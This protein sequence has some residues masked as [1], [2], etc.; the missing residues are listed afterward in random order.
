MNLATARD[1]AMRYS[2]YRCREC[3]TEGVIRGVRTKGS[4]CARHA[5]KNY[6]TPQRRLEARRRQL[7]W[8]I[9]ECLFPCARWPCYLIE[10]RYE[11]IHQTELPGGIPIYE[12]VGDDARTLRERILDLTMRDIIRA[13]KINW[14]KCVAKVRESHTRDT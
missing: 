14:R 2:R 6:W 4:R 13:R 3:Q 10:D 5:L 1:V 7:V 8:L 11:R 12:V 9:A